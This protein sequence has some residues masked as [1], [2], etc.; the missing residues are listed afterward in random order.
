MFLRKI[1]AFCAVLLALSLP[2]KV[3]AQVYKNGLIDKTVA[4]IGNES[5]LLSQV[6]EQV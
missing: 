2:V 1:S 6:E 3:S 5:I 4:L